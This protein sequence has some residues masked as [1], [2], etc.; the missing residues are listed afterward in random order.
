MR[1]V[2]ELMVLYAQVQG[3]QSMLKLLPAG[4]IL[5]NE[6]NNCFLTFFV[7][8]NVMYMYNNYLLNIIQKYIKKF[9]L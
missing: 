1:D 5:F 3:D 2:E 9:S 8:V 4:S 7:I 6:M